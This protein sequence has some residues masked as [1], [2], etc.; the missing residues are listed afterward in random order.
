MKTENVLL[1]QDRGGPMRAKLTDFGIAK[2]MDGHARFGLETGNKK[3]L[4]SP[5]YMSPEQCMGLGA[6]SVDERADVY[7]L[8]TV[9]YEMVCG[10]RPYTGNS[11]FV[12][13][14]KLTSNEPFPRPIELR[15]EIPAAW[16]ALI[17][18]ALAHRREDRI[19]TVK[20]L[21]RGLAEALPGGDALLSY[22]APRLIDNAI[23]PNAKTISDAMGVAVSH[24]TA[25]SQTST[26]TPRR[27]SAI[28][29]GAARSAGSGASSVGSR[30]GSS[31][32]RARS[33][34]CR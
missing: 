19:Q 30:P 9:I 24:W 25:T 14:N 16:D 31:S 28:T 10:Q 33:P 6:G 11:M 18:A 8:G 13:I 12:L 4:G 26:A 21:I 3:T 27:S 7:S 22:V 32:A 34:C 2:L 29:A 5:G 23:A 15:P 17:M 1:A 20:E